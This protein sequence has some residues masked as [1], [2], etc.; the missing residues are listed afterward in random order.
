MSKTESRNRDEAERGSSNSV[1]PTTPANPTGQPSAK[2]PP[3][4]ATPSYPTHAADPTGV[5]RPGE[6]TAAESE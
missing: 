2:H 1:D 3:K 5:K 4:P 6:S